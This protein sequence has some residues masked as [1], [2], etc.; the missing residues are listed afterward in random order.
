MNKSKLA[1]HRAVAAVLMV[2]FAG[3]A[4]VRTSDP[5]ADHS[6]ATA[7]IE[8]AVHEIM[9]AAET[10]DFDRLDALH[11]YGP[12]FTKFTSSSPQRLDATATRE[13]E[14]AG[15]GALQGLKMRADELKIDLFGNVGVATLIL[16]YSFEHGGA[17]IRK[18]DRTTLVFVND[19][20]TWKVA[21]EH[22]SPIVQP[23]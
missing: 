7:Q 12:N 6:E 9:V 16:D 4:S 5:H 17:T 23:L 2:L 1:G 20:G 3:C 11:L 18:R 22:L 10:K 8:R 13:G 21:H 19:G 15:L 14:H